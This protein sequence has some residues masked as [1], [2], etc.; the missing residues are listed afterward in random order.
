MNYEKHYNL[1]IERARNRNLGTTY[2]EKHHVV[3]KCMGGNNS[4]SNLARLTPEEHYVAHQLL[5][6]MFP[7]HSGLAHAA[8]LMTSHQTDN[9]SKNKLYG[10][11]RKRMSLDSS[12]QRKA[13]FEN[14]DHPKGFL[15]KKHSDETRAQIAR[16]TKEALIASIGVRVYTYNL[17]GTLYKEFETIAECAKHLGTNPSNVKYTA[18]GR[19]SH[20]KNK[21]IRYD[22]VFQMEPYVKPPS[23]NIGKIRSEETVA[24]WRLTKYGAVNE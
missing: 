7:H 8:Q 9:R 16:S 21:M 4:K 6:K 2:T 19:F 22:Y 13:W 12:K 10:W 14:N 5:C 20:C 23:K 24:K 1:L 11:L 18:E 15:G 3:P 17:D